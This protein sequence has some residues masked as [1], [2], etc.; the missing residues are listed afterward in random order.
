MENTVAA[1]RAPET[2]MTVLRQTV[3]DARAIR[4]LRGNARG[5]AAAVLAEVDDFH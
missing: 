1:R 5:V 2:T 4:S 3:M